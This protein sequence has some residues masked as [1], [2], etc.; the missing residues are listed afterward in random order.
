M[1]R[2]RTE[3]IGYSFDAND[4]KSVMELLRQM[5]QTCEIIIWNP[6]AEVICN[7]LQLSY[8][9]LAGSIKPLVKPF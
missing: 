7:D 6:E 1:D 9:G 5:P 2:L 8:P 4:R 3:V